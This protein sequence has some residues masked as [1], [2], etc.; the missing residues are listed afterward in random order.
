MSRAQDQHAVHPDG[1]EKIE[2]FEAN[3][4]QYRQAIWNYFAIK[5]NREA[6]DDL[7]QHVFMKAIENLH[8]FNEN[9]SLF[10]WIFTIAR[11][12]AKNEYRSRSR[13]KEYTSDFAELEAS[14]SISLD[15][16]KYVEIRIDIGSAL[17]KLNELDQHIISLHFFMDCTLA[18]VAGIVGM[19]QS[20]VKNRLY[21]ALEKLRKQL[22]DWGDIAIMSIQELIEIVSKNEQSGDGSAGGEKKVH[23]DVLRELNGSV[24]QLAKKLKHQP[25]QKIVIEIYPDL[26]AFHQAVGEP[27]A[28]NWFMGTFAGNTLKIVSPLDPGPNHTYQSI[29]RSTTH[30]FA[31]WLVRDIN[32]TAPKWLCQ[33]IGGYEAKQ[34]SEQFLKDTTADAIRSGTIPTLD[35]L[36]NDTWDFET[37]GGFQFSYL[38]VEFLERTYGLD[39]LN[40]LIRSPGNCS[41]ILGRTESELREQ[42]I[43][44]LSN[45]P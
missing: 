44:Y 32:P 12:T 33:G 45:R 35:Q 31:M 39:A 13:K 40:Q 22:K 43:Q 27:D 11:N 24:E 1:Q 37:M 17:G 30:L 29:L 41:G 20:A 8:R 9:A 4:N 23:Q 28:P 5:V 42:W 14:Q 19:R 36:E 21:R 15:F 16:A 26:P 6:A 18:E 2:R 25:S 7:T 38:M 3:Y 10:T 34:M